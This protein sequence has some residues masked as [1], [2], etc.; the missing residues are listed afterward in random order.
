MI[1]CEKV[2]N[3]DIWT[4]MSRCC[5]VINAVEMMDINGIKTGTRRIQ[6][7]DGVLQHLP[8]SIQLG[9]F[10]GS[11]L[12]PGQSKECRKCGSL[13]HLAAACTHDI[14]RICK[15]TDHISTQC[16]APVKCNLCSSVNHRFKDCPLAYSNRVKLSTASTMG[17]VNQRQISED[18]EPQALKKD[19]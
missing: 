3:Q 9:A 10:R 4:W 14:C 2:R 18:P 12:Y 17:V 13:S 6:R 1:F 7:K 8:S 11:V 15:S 5:E 16:P 19:L